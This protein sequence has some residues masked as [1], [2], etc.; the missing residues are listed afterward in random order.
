MK[1]RHTVQF[2]LGLATLVT[3]L[4]ASDQSRA[5]SPTPGYNTEIPAGLL[6]ADK[7]ETSIGDLEFSDG[8]P[9]QSTVEKVYDFLDTS[10]AVDTFLKGMPAASLH[11]L[12]EGAHSLGAV[13]ANEVIIF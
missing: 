5:D 11:A 4:V 2:A 12:I 7:V 9:T 1:I 6:T 13:E 3:G 10:R 8:V